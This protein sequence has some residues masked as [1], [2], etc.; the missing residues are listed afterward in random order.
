MEL[1]G[2]PGVYL[3]GFRHG[4]EH[5][6]VLGQHDRERAIS[7]ARSSGWAAGRDWSS[8]KRP[9]ADEL[10]HAMYLGGLVALLGVLVGVRIRQIIESR[11]E[12]VVDQVHELGQLGSEQLLE[13]PTGKGAGDE[14]PNVRD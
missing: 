9:S 13:A 12:L 4:L 8:G 10:T 5:G 11:R 1:D 14:L 2:D 6:S 7:E 3:E